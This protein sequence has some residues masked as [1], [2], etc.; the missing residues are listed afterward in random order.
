MS[1]HSQP[2][3]WGGDAVSLVDAFRSGER[4]PLEELDATLAAIEASDLNAFSFLD[5]ER[6]REA[7]ADADVS[8]PF[9]GVPLAVKELDAVA[10]WPFT[11]A[12]FPLRDQIAGFA[13]RALGELVARSF[14][15]VRDSLLRDP[16]NSPTP[17]VPPST[18]TP[19]SCQP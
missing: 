19:R 14:P 9:G 8:K 13:D 16:P 15:A 1:D 12:S 5:T 10:G 11:E 18:P 4:S 17:S 3:P 2:Q 6:A 7:A